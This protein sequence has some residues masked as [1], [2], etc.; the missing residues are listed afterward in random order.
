MNNSTTENSLNCSEDSTDNTSTIVSY[1]NDCNDYVNHQSF[2]KKFDSD[3]YLSNYTDLKKNTELLEKIDS[4][5]NVEEICD[6]KNYFTK[7]REDYVRASGNLC[8]LDM[9]VYGMVDKVFFEDFAKI[10]KRLDELIDPQF[11]LP[12]IYDEDEI[13]GYDIRQYKKFNIPYDVFLEYKKVWEDKDEDF[14][15]I[16]EF[17]NTVCTEWYKMD[18][19]GE[20]YGGFWQYP[21]G[22]YER[23]NAWKLSGDDNCQALCDLPY[24]KK[25]ILHTIKIGCAMRTECVPFTVYLCEWM[26]RKMEQLGLH[27]Q[28]SK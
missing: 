21:E 6:L 20:C 8:M 3:Q 11:K 2:I 27:E 1:F 9:G 26:K 19:H 22:S 24:P 15:F 4:I 16:E 18:R 12:V 7:F 14:N 13:N 28:S 23:E 10:D 25:F 17:Y 5:K